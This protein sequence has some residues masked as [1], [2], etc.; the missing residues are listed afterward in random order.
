M[1]GRLLRCV[2][3]L[4][5][6]VTCFAGGVAQAGMPR[7]LFDEVPRYLAL[8]DMS[9][10]RLEAISFFIFVGLLSAAAIRYIWNS[11]QRDFPRLPHLTYSKAVGLLMLWGLLFVLVL[12]MISGARELMTPGAWEPNGATYRLRSEKD[13]AANPEPLP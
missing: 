11:L 6:I 13:V 10:T 7:V 1:F 3:L 9:R 8:T 12:T 5:C 2:P 4:A